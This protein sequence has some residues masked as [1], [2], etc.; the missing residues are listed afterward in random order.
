VLHWPGVL[1]QRSVQP[2]RCLHRCRPKTHEYS[3]ASQPQS[4][5]KITLLCKRMQPACAH[6]SL[7]ALQR[8][9]VPLPEH[10][11]TFLPAKPK[12]EPQSSH[13]QARIWQERGVGTG[14]KAATRLHK[15]DI[16]HF[17]QQWRDGVLEVM[18]THDRHTIPCSCAHPAKSQRHCTTRIES[19]AQH[20]CRQQG[21]DNVLAR[22]RESWLPILSRKVKES[23]G[24]MHQVN[25]W[26]EKPDHQRV[27]SAQHH[28]T[29][30]QHAWAHHDQACAATGAQACAHA[31]ISDACSSLLQ[32]ALAS[33]LPAA[34]AA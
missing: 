5:G 8:V 17:R 23:V 32:T 12:G 33:T 1:R 16:C 11:S 28:L 34:Q 7:R 20:T 14:S 9:Q 26:S 18:K 3:G 15:R 25:S 22:P 4:T 31:I 29:T 6:N 24:E 27:C 19:T 21:L 30:D 10:S 2:R 13:I